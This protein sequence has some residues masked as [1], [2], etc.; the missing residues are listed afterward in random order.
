MSS[1]PTTDE[2]K[3]EPWRRRLKQAI[4][5]R[6]LSYKEL[7]RD[8][9]SNAEYV[10]KVLNGRINPTIDRILKIC[11]VAAIEPSFLFATNLEPR[12][13]NRVLEDV[14]DLSEREAKLVSR[15][16]QSAR[17]Q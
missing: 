13:G 8:A 14:K 9:G 15:L 4:D 7:S 3:D 12:D 6:G 5:D 2:R 17:S 1:Q 16:I 11:E 10:S